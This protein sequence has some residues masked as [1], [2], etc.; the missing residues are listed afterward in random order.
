LGSLIP[1]E[2]L[3]E[4]LSSSTF[5]FSLLIPFFG[6]VFYL[7]FYGIGSRLPYIITDQDPYKDDPYGILWHLFYY[8][9][10]LVNLLTVLA[11]TPRVKIPLLSDWGQYTVYPYLLHY[12]LLIVLKEIGFFVPNA[13]V[14]L[15]ILYFIL[16][17]LATCCLSTTL[18][19]RIT[20]PMI[21]PNLSCLFVQESA[22]INDGYKSLE[23]GILKVDGFT[24]KLLSEN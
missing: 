8:A 19:R 17:F 20:W 9:V 18:S 22:K 12:L 14:G 4:R 21:E 23:D 6:F 24:T 1:R 15:V 7:G 10:V 2:Y 13:N 11:W 5:R 16:P 3:V